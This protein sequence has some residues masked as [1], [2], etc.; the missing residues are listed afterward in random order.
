MIK[1]NVCRKNLFVATGVLNTNKNDR[2]YSQLFYHKLPF[3]P[4]LKPD[5]NP[6]SARIRFCESVSLYP[7][8]N[9]IETLF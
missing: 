8:E 6:N 3:K 7:V 4:D 1:V 9:V 2:P 5:Q